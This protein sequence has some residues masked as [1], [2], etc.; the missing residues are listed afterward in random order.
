MDRFP[1]PLKSAEMRSTVRVELIKIPQ[2]YNNIETQV[3]VPMAS[4]IA[5][6]LPFCCSGKVKME[7]SNRASQRHKNRKE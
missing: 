7:L 4:I 1:E 6:E 5:V 3:I 2:P